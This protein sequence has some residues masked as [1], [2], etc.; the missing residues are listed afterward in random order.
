MSGNIIGKD[1]LRR[2]AAQWTLEHSV[3][4]F[5]PLGATK[6]DYIDSFVMPE[7]EYSHFN[8]YVDENGDIITM[9]RAEIILKP[10]ASKTGRKEQFVFFKLLRT[11][12]ST[13]DVIPETVGYIILK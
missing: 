2:A 12:V 6:N 8:S 7:V 9:L 10:S 5:I 4:A 1:D 11:F 13:P 3:C